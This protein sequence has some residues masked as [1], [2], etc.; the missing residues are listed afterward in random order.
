MKAVDEVIVS[1]K[2]DSHNWVQTEHTL[3][4]KSG[5][6]IWTANLPLFDIGFW[7]P[8]RKLS[9]IDKWRLQ[10]AVNAWHK[11]EGVFNF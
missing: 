6:E 5:V 2:N 11:H 8:K 10:R 4:H 9:F 3:N 7:Y 1:L